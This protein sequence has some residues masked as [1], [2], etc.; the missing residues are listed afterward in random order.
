L[1]ESVKYGA[2]RGEDSDIQKGRLHGCG[3]ACLC[4]H[5]WT[6]MYAPLSAPFFFV[7]L[8]GCM[9]RGG[10]LPQGR[11]NVHMKRPKTPAK[12]REATLARSMTSV[13]CGRSIRLN[14]IKVM[15]A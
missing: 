8:A 15:S 7:Q 10:A 9:S 14:F 2:Q 11:P 12:A 13:C 3:P 4:L 1:R 6:L 5:L